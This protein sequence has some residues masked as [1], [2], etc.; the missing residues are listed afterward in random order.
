[1]QNKP[2]VPWGVIIFVGFALALFA[3]AWPTLASWKRWYVICAGVLLLSAFAL[4]AL[5]RR[6]TR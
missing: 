5:A 1:M 6:R 3:Q 2:R 4:D